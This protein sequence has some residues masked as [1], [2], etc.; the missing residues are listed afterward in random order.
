MSTAGST[1]G[2]LFILCWW[3]FPGGAGT[4]TRAF[5]MQTM[6]SRLW[7]ISLAWI[8]CLFPYSLLVERSME[9]DLTVEVRSWWAL[10]ALYLLWVYLQP[11]FCIASSP[12]V[13]IPL[14]SRSFCWSQ[15][16]TENLLRN[17]GVEVSPEVRAVSNGFIPPSEWKC[18]LRSAVKTAK[19]CF[20]SIAKCEVRSVWVSTSL[21]YLQKHLI[22]LTVSC[23]LFP[24][25]CPMQT[26]GW[27]LSNMGS[28]INTKKSN[29]WAVHC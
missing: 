4:P 7:T 3:I 22:T 17:T 26:L 5:H 9:Y 10:L 19:Q 28:N 23:Y 13:L 25:A 24:G 15:V 14:C 11:E 16:V 8:I 6:F 18:V 20:T 29:L 27:K 1:Q 21:N 12:V 2:L